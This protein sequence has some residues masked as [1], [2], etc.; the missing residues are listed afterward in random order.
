M[1]QPNFGDAGW[2]ASTRCLVYVERA[3]RSRHRWAFELVADLLCNVDMF[4]AEGR[5]KIG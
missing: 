5:L 4:I 3:Y 2:S 1:P